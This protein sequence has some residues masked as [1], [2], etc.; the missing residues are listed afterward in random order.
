VTSLH[1]PS[2]LR[3][4]SAVILAVLAVLLG[5]CG[6]GGGAD[7]TP[8]APVACTTC[9]TSTADVLTVADTQNIIA[10]AV[11]EANARGLHATIAVSDRVGNILAVYRMTGAQPDVLI[12]SFRGVV[13]GL[14]GFNKI[15]DTYAAVSKAVTAAY[16]S[17][18]GN[19]FSTRTASQIVQENFDP[20]ETDAPAGPLFGVQFSS[21][22]C[23]DFVNPASTLA[24]PHSS[25]LGLSAGPGGL[26][27]YK[28]GVTVGGIGVVADGL[29]TFDTG[30]ATRAP[31][32]N[33]AIALAGTTGYAA[34]AAITADKI[35]AGGLALRFINPVTLLSTPAAHPAFGSLAGSIVAGPGF[36]AGTVLQGQ[37]FGASGSGIR[38]DTGVFKAVNG[39]V[40]VDGN[41]TP[42]F[43][44][45]AS[46]DGSFT[47]ADVT[48]ILTSAMQ[49]VNHTRAQIRQPLNTVAQVSITVVDRGG[50]ILGL[51][52]TPDAPVFGLDVAVQKAR[53]VLFFSDPAAA[54]TLAALP[55]A[56]YPATKTPYAISNYLA[57]SQQFFSNPNVF[58]DGTAYS[59]RAIGDISRPFYPDGI[60]GNAPGPLYKPFASW[61]IFD[62]GLQ[63]DLALNAILAGTP[64]NCTGIPEVPNGIQIFA[65]A[66]PIYKNGTLIGA[67]GVS[68]DGT[69][70]DDM[71]SFLGLGNASTILANGIGN[72]PAAIRADKLAPG[73]TGTHLQYALCPQ[74]PFVD[75]NQ[76][77]V[78]S[79]L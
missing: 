33:E 70:Q 28:A 12:T 47:V 71:V 25:P 26:P 39:Y 31:D 17:S 79:G 41:N 68:G 64:G 50:K 7:T 60:N 54:A 49:V 78:C 52:R 63:L 57:A 59:D 30:F 35:T 62:D 34:P 29:Y 42:R 14:E 48:Q 36:T 72:A 21:L 3:A 24:G 56:V 65:G 43:P 11:G 9:N 44:P 51:V 53:T 69:S 45:T 58:A 2:S 76:Q 20:G 1:L 55:P 74:T 10:Q 27:L 40:L 61:S 73:G 16:L 19:A 18:N 13:G 66:V 75:T 67:I 23:G 32:V 77:D 15:P 8:A 38:A 37:A 22:P 5:S 46:A 4:L 6:G